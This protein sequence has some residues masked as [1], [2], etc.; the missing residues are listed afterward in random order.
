MN[1][2]KTSWL[3]RLVWVSGKRVEGRRVA[4]SV[5][6]FTLYILQEFIFYDILHIY[7]TIFGLS[8]GLVSNKIRVSSPEKFIR[9][10]GRRHVF[11]DL[12]NF[13]IQKN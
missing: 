9:Y 12:C 8:S 6:M 2:L 10:L 11:F 3:T 4:L 1:I 5:L 13:Y 7:F